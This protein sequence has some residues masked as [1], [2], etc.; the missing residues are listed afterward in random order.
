MFECSF[1]LNLGKRIS[2]L[3]TYPS[4][5]GTKGVKSHKSQYAFMYN[6]VEP[7]RS[8]KKCLCSNLPF[9]PSSLCKIVKQYKLNDIYNTIIK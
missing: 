8:P 6:H 7:Y 9:L 2:S 3:N 4:E 1:Y 5:E